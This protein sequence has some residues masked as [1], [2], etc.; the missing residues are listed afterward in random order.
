MSLSGDGQTVSWIWDGR[1][2]LR[3]ET[4]SGQSE[5]SDEQQILEASLNHDGSAMAIV[6]AAEVAVWEVSSHRR[7]WAAPNTTWVDQEVDWS[8]DGSTLVLFR[9]DLGTVLL[10]S[11]TGDRLA[12]IAISKPAGFAPQENVLGDLRHRISRADRS[13][14]LYALPPP[15][16]DPPRVSLERILNEAGLELRGV[17]LVSIL[18]PEGSPMAQARL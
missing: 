8:I 2:L 15:D 13:W 1:V 12:T 5:F 3:R 18:P 4:A 6:T 7:R 17:E 14:E 11:A 10:D 16:A 9:E